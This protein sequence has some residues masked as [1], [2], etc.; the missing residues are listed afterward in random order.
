MSYLAVN[1]LALVTWPWA[2]IV[3]AGDPLCS[4]CLGR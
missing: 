3:G 2:I 4:L 1:M